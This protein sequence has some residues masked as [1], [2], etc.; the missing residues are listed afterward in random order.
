MAKYELVGHAEVTHDAGGE[1]QPLDEMWTSI[2]QPF[3]LRGATL[4]AVKAAIRG[5]LEGWEEVVGRAFLTI[6]TIRF[7]RTLMTPVNP[8]PIQL[9]VMFGLALADQRIA[10]RHFEIE[11]HELQEP[12][13][14]DHHLGPTVFLVRAKIQVV[15]EKQ[16]LISEDRYARTLDDLRSFYERAAHKAELLTSFLVT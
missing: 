7:D 15:F 5:S 16:L 9:S 14:K 11:P 8:R 12:F 6:P 3:L 1:G 13:G 2:F 4:D 10:E